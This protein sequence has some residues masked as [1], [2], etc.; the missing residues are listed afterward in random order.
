MPDAEIP[1]RNGFPRQESLHTYL[2]KYMALEKSLCEL[3][4]AEGDDAAYQYTVYYPDHT[5]SDDHV[6]HSFEDCKHAAMAFADSGAAAVTITKRWFG[7]GL[8][9]IDARFNSGIDKLM[10]VSPCGVTSDEGTEMLCI[11]TAMWF[12]FPTPFRRGD[13]VQYRS[14]YYESKPFV[15]NAI[16]DWAPCDPAWDTPGDPLPAKKKQN[17]FER[18]MLGGDSSDMIAWEYFVDDDGQLYP[19]SI[20]DYTKLV[21][22]QKTV[23]EKPNPESAQQLYGRKDRHSAAAER[24]ADH[25]AGGSRKAESRA[26]PRHRR[27]TAV[28]GSA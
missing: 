1:A 17:P 16:F 27:R 7:E 11:F 3:F 25:P 5:E 2:Q 24:T 22:N 23:R 26:S 13:I 4:F 19:K 10:S 28:G 12:S 21:Y 6:L 15:L 20:P 18:L 9:S 8:R 14:P